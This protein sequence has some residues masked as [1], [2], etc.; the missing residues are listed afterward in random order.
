[1]HKILSNSIQ[2]NATQKTLLATG[3]VLGL[4]SF[5]AQ[6][7]LTSETVNGQNLVYDSGINATWTQDGSR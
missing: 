4:A 1:M 2:Y 5:S 6:A 7:T 3:L